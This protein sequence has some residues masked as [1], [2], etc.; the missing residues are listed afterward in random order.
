MSWGAVIVWDGDDAAPGCWHGHEDSFNW[1]DANAYLAHLV[2][3]GG[4]PGLRGRA[5]LLRP[6]SR[7]GSLANTVDVIRHIVVN[8]LCIIALLDLDDA[9]I[10]DRVFESLH[11][12]FAFGGVDV[13]AGGGL[14][15][16]KAGPVRMTGVA[17]AVDC[18]VRIGEPTYAVTF[19]RPPR[20]LR[21][22]GAVWSHLRA[23]RKVSFDRIT[24]EQLE[25][26][27]EVLPCDWVYMVPLADMAWRGATPGQ[28]LYLYEPGT[29]RVADHIS[30]RETAITAIL[31]RPRSARLVPTI[32]VIGDA[33]I[34]RRVALPAVDGIGLPALHTVEVAK[35]AR[36]L[37]AALKQ[38]GYRL[39]TGGLGGVMA[40]AAGGALD[41]P[42]GP[43]L[44]SYATA[45]AAA[46]AAHGL[47]VS[48]CGNETAA[49]VGLLPAMNVVGSCP[50]VDVPLATGLGHGRN[51]VVATAADAVIIIGGGAGTLW[52]ASA[53]WT[54]RRMLIAIAGTGGTADLLAG[55]RVD[56]RRRLHSS[57]FAIAG[58][59]EAWAEDC[60]Y[61]ATS[62]EHV[63]SLLEERLHWYRCEA[64]L[65]RTAE[66]W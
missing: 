64:M 28:A 55:Q 60:V 57:E 52:E 56:S 23:A 21:G 32:A 36:E 61:S 3:G 34:G 11:A 33:F 22:G 59:A 54:Q 13:F 31:A 41:A 62:I 49:S 48:T 26:E 10:G 7:R 1:H 6:R 63:L 18:P 14:R 51:D 24:E 43:P 39:L 50:A 30:S 65:P 58:R 44:R 35:I 20:L 27:R 37:G 40:A 25:R 9:L 53:A 16:D 2:E 5:T 66:P 47:T 29:H 19:D 4:M 38:A 17:A 15:T 42:V 45:Q 12:A 8:P 46:L